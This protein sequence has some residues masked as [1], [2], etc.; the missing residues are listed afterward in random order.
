MTI[1]GPNN[2]S[3]ASFGPRYMFFLIIS[4]CIFELINDFYIFLGSIYVLEARRDGAGSRD[5]NG[6][7]VCV[8]FFTFVFFITN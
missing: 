1:T 5:N 7:Y 6:P 3:S 4:L 8:F 2:V